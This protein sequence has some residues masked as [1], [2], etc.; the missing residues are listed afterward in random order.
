MHTVDKLYSERMCTSEKI[1]TFKIKTTLGFNSLQQ[2]APSNQL[3]LNNQGTFSNSDALGIGQE[4]LSN[5]AESLFSSLNEDN[6]GD[7]LF[8]INSLEGNYE[9]NLNDGMNNAGVGQMDMNSFEDT[10]VKDDSG[11]LNGYTPHHKETHKIGDDRQGIGDG[12]G[13][14]FK[15]DLNEIIISIVTFKTLIFFTIGGRR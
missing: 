14:M 7:S 11:L 2:F 9:S 5:R 13:N 3:G 1:K 12:G 8:G 6:E 4:Q 15:I 10:N